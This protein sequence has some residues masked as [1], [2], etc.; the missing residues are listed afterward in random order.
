MVREGF[1][2]QGRSLNYHLKEIV[3]ID[4]R[5]PDKKQTM[6]SNSITSSL[7]YLRLEGL[8]AFTSNERQ[9]PTRSSLLNLDP[10]HRRGFWSP[11]L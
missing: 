10:T 7:P 8:F 4:L 11:G 3:L 1:S 6:L 5:Q 2:R 9:D